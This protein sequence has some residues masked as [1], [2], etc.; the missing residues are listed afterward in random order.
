MSDNSDT[1]DVYNLH[2]HYEYEFLHDQNKI[3]IYWNYDN[4]TLD[5]LMANE[6]NIICYPETYYFNGSWVDIV[7]RLF[8]WEK[9]TDLGISMYHYVF[10]GEIVIFR[11]RCLGTVCTDWYNIKI[12]HDGYLCVKPF[13]GNT[14][15][16][17]FVK[18]NCMYNDNLKQEN[19]TYI[20]K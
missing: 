7:K 6:H 5:T 15:Q 18:C 9:G 10:A 19:D 2:E 1:I 12:D 4:L 8:S 14:R 13:V 20:L 11:V 3:R 17:E 16:N